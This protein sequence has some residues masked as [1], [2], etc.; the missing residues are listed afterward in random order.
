M[1]DEMKRV[2]MMNSYP[3]V[4]PF[5]TN[6]RRD[7][8][9]IHVLLSS[10]F[11]STVVPWKVDQRVEL[12]SVTWVA[13]RACQRA[14]PR[15]T[16]VPLDPQQVYPATAIARCTER[17]SRGTNPASFFSLFSFLHLD[18]LAT[19]SEVAC[20]KIKI[21]TLLYMEIRLCSCLQITLRRR[22]WSIIILSAQFYNIL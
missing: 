4:W 3:K 8:W 16:H 5:C 10:V 17:G 12:T 7:V 15:D 18:P 6:P 13:T 9:F 2:R 22:K 11:N 14:K 19:V 21:N 1:L 20:P